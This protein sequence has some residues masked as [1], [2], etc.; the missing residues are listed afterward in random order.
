MI[1][2]EEKAETERKK[3]EREEPDVQ[4]VTQGKARRV[5]CTLCI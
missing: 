5:A 4:M 2:V 1:L 3:K